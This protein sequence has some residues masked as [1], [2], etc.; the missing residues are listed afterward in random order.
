M[1][2]SPIVSIVDS[3]NNSKTP[4]IIDLISS[5]MV[6]VNLLTGVSIQVSNLTWVFGSITSCIPEEILAKEVSF[7]SIPLEL[8]FKLSK[9]VWLV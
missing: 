1:L 8:D 9:M 5:V 4:T 7:L 6:D 2:A 3:S